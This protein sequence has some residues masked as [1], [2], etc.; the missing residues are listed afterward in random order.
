MLCRYTVVWFLSVLNIIHVL[1]LESVLFDSKHLYNVLL[2][3][4]FVFHLLSLYVDLW[5]GK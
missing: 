3:T 5:N 4:C 2:L 1:D